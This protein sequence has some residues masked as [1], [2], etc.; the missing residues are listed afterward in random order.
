MFL[1]RPYVS[2]FSCL[3]VAYMIHDICIRWCQSFPRHSGDL[4]TSLLP[5][6]K[7][8][9]KCKEMAGLCFP[10]E[11]TTQENA[12]YYCG[13]SVAISKKPLAT[14]PIE[15]LHWNDKALVVFLLSPELM[16]SGESK[17][18]HKEYYLLIPSI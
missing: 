2:L 14:F 11:S 15:S 17:M 6:S 13:H 7:R 3:D 18:G 5:P 9:T 12:L 10:A 1:T 8:Q 4:P 16:C